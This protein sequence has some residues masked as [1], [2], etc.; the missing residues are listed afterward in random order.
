ML[1]RRGKKGFFEAK[2]GKRG[3]KPTP[4]AQLKLRGSWR[5]NRNPD[6]PSFEPSIP[7]CPSFL[8]AEGKREWRR[9][10]KVLGAAS[11]ITE[12]DR[13]A[14]ALLCHAW[15]EFV[16]ADKLVAE[17]HLTQRSDRGG[18]YI[19]P[20]VN[21]RTSA[22]SR[23]LKAAAEFG[24]TPSARSRVKVGGQGE[25][26]GQKQGKQRFFAGQNA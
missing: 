1:H 7:T 24:C 17:T 9:L 19:N 4:T 15:S 5:A 2:M 20:A 16:A 14:L 21:V 8:D 26:E 11:V 12:A 18:Y 10:C 6:E 22:W 3:P 25:Q 13:G 23:Y